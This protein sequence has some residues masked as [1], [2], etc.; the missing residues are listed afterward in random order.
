MIRTLGQGAFGRTLLARD[1]QSGREVAIKMLD[2]QK[3]DSFK[4]FE[5]FEREASVMRAVRH[6]GVPEI[7]DSLKAR[8]EGREAAFLVMEFIEGKSLE[9]LI[10]ERHH[11]DPTDA[12][13]IL[14]EL[15]GV[16]DYLH[17]RVP[18][19]L[20]RDIKPANII[21]RPDGYPTLVDFG[22]VRS[23]IAPAGQ[24]GSTIVGTYG[25]MPYEQHMG[26]ATPASD[27]YALAATFLHL[28][29]GNAPPQFMNAEGRIEVPSTL[30]GGERQQQVLSRMLRPSPAQRFQSARE[31]RQALLATEAVAV[32][33]SPST[34][35]LT[36][37]AV[38]A[39][40]ALPPAPRPLQGEARE[41]FDKLAPSMWRYMNSAGS[42]TG[43]GGAWGA[44]A[45]IFLGLVTFGV[46]PAIVAARAGG[47]RRRLRRFLS[48]GTP[49]IAE[50][51]SIDSEKDELGIRLGRVRFQF[52]VD[53]VLHR[54][55]DTVLQSVA[56]R[57]R[58]GDQ[59]EILYIPEEDYDGI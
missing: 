35:A 1:E 10:A 24:D 9:A 2:T 53:G 28:L 39:P 56:D 11:L 21:L 42:L 14:L 46:L 54:D 48:L 51:I 30:P 47:R 29:T 7:Y 38:P 45:S 50:I 49:A 6:H 23:A 33:A 5:L 52:Q 31:V 4:G 3:V 20:H 27:L 37:R 41:R 12:S 15:L 34:Q 8:W 36:H 40:M 13:H 22:A 17:S 44:I 32:A 57:W 18:P 59:V 16:L 55:S 58:P 25:Y 26:Q 19:I 43:G